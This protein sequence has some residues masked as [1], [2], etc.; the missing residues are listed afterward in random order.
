MPSVVGSL[1]FNL[2]AS[3]FLFIFAIPT[4]GKQIRPVAI[5]PVTQAMTSLV[6]AWNDPEFP[7]DYITKQIYRVFQKDLN[8]K[9]IFP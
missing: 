7:E 5:S 4:V 8:D 1:H 3:F 9:N 6:L 2:N